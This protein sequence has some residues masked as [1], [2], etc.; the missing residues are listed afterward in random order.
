[1]RDG[2]PARPGEDFLAEAPIPTRRLNPG[3]VPIWNN[4]D[5]LHPAKR[6]VTLDS[7]PGSSPAFRG[8]D[9]GAAGMTASTLNWETT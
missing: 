5:G 3:G 4:S 1:M 2:K 9:S 8:M 6:G 7:D